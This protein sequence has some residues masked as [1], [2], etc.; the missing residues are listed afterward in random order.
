[1]AKNIKGFLEILFEYFFFF[2][3]MVNVNFSND[4]KFKYCCE[5]YPEILQQVSLK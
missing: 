2:N 4:L 5:C 3:I 1:M